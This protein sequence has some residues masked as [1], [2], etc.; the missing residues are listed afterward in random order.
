V[1]LWKLWNRWSVMGQ[2]RN[3][4]FHRNWPTNVEWRVPNCFYLRWVGL[5]MFEYLMPL[6][7]DKG[8]EGTRRHVQTCFK[9]MTNIFISIATWLFRGIMGQAFGCLQSIELTV[10]KCFWTYTL[11]YYEARF[12]LTL[13]SYTY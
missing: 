5:V 10:L 2:S 13:F 8:S 11:T 6:F 9:S 1:L 7:S 4:G 12:C 3:N